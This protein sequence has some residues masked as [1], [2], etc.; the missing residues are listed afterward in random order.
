V[1]R[2]FI[3]LVLFL[4]GCTVSANSMV[5]QVEKTLLRSVDSPAP[6]NFNQ[7]TPLYRYYLPNHMGKRESNRVSTILLSD[8]VEIVMNLDIAAVVMYR[9]YRNELTNGLRP[10]TEVNRN[11]IDTRGTFRHATGEVISYRVTVWEFDLSIH[12]VTLQTNYF[13]FTAITPLAKIDAVLADMI[14][15]AKSAVTDR[16]EIISLYSNKQII[17]YQQQVVELFEQIAPDSGR[18]I[19]MINIM[20]GTLSFNRDYT[21]IDDFDIINDYENDFIDNV[22]Q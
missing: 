2:W 5:Q 22:E 11:W 8:G 21:Q 10:Y 9:F 4:T 20:N 14:S 13:V 17:N 7:L 19:D 12:V 6:P 1:R 18:I 16:N 15:I 3:I